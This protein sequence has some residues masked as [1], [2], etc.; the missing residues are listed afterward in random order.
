M[1][2]DLVNDYVK[3]KRN[4]RQDSL[5]MICVMIMSRQMK[6]EISVN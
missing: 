5:L 4:T 6:R 3:Q 2:S 1:I